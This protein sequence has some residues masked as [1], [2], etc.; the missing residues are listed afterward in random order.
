[1]KRFQNKKIMT[2][3]NYY[4]GRLFLTINSDLLYLFPI[5]L[6]I[7][8]KVNMW[9]S[10]A[11][12]EHTASY[13]SLVPSHFQKRANMWLI[14]HESGLSAKKTYFSLH[15]LPHIGSNVLIIYLCD[16]EAVEYFYDKMDGNT[17]IEILYSYEVRADLRQLSLCLPSSVH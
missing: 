2:I 4:L 13:T 7:C 10:V 5:F 14:N 6:Q 11:A 3:N 8:N 1:M 12:P 15:I 16:V 9:W 17:S